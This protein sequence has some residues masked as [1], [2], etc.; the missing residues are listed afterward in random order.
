LRMSLNILG[1]IPA[2]LDSTRFPGKPLKKIIHKP[3]IQWVY[4]NSKRATLLN[5]VIVATDSS[6]IL[7][8]VEQFGGKAILTRK[9]HKTGLDRVIEVSGKMDKFT[10]FVNIQG[11]EPAIH[12]ET[13]DGIARMLL[14][15]PDCATAT[16]AIPFSKVE[17]FMSPHQ[18]KV[19]FDKNFKALYFSRSPIPWRQDSA[20]VSQAYKHLGIYG[21]DRQTLLQIQLLPPGNIENLEKLEQLRM[22]ENNIPIYVYVT[23]HDSVGVDTPEDIAKAENLLK[24]IAH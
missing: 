6:E 21:Y 14:N 11:D 16:A 18:V 17:N 19:V 1:V 4:E 20:D 3:M 12:P 23:A 24:Y 7:D 13:I 2:R 8:A 10:H 22:L 5:D 15:H 9:D